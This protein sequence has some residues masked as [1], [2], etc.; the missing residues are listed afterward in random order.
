MNKKGTGE[1]DK[2][3]EEFEKYLLIEYGEEVFNILKTP[4]LGMLHFS[5]DDLFKL[6]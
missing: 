6:N 4:K 2:I 1:V 3:R 5:Y